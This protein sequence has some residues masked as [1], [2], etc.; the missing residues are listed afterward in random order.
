MVVISLPAPQLNWG[1]H[2]VG[3]RD[4]VTTIKREEIFGLLV[5]PTP[6]IKNG[7]ILSNTRIF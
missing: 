3:Y 1:R 4:H 2:R 6:V 7:N 5:Y